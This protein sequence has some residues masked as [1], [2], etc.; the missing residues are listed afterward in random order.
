[1]KLYDNWLTMQLELL[2]TRNTWFGS[3]SK[4]SHYLQLAFLVSIFISYCWLLSNFDSR[5]QFWY[6][7]CCYAI[8]Y[9]R[10][11]VYSQIDRH[12]SRIF[13]T[14]GNGSSWARYYIQKINAQV[15]HTQQ[16]GGC[17]EKDSDVWGTTALI[18]SEHAHAA[19]FI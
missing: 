17:V 3:F 18:S 1:M 5:H 8:L 4:S 15:H 2:N 7:V 6:F 13:R 19:I 10:F 9:R 16:C 11:S 12:V 14:W